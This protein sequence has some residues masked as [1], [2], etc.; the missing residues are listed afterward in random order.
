MIQNPDVQAPELSQFRTFSIRNEKGP[1]FGSFRI[2]DV[3]IL[4]HSG[5]WTSGFWI[6]PDFGRPDLRRLTVPAK[7]KSVE[8]NGIRS[9]K[10]FIQNLAMQ[11]IIRL[12]K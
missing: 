11:K 5:F 2:L 12:L 8:R 10:V 7:T 4:D 3:R 1:D 9:N 6:I